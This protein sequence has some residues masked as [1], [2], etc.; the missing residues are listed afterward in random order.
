[1]TTAPFGGCN[2]LRDAPPRS[3]P[4]EAPRRLAALRTSREGAY[5]HAGPFVFIV[6]GRSLMLR[7]TFMSG[8]AVVAGGV[9]G[10]G[11]ALAAP[12]TYRYRC[13]RCQLIE[14]YGQ[15]GIK[16]CPKD[17]FTMIKMND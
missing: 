1:M 14:T 5:T 2:A 10:M 4:R 9:V 7:R 15:P 17:G 8:I 13:P 3:T 6:S 11:R 12:K 16:K